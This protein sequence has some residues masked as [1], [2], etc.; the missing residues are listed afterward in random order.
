MKRIVFTL[1]VL[2]AAA[3]AGCNERQWRQADKAVADVNNVAVGARAVLESPAG[4]AIPTPV[5]EIAGVV[6]TTLLGGAA[7]YQ[8]WRKNQMTKTTRAIVRGVEMIDREH[9]VENPNP[10][11]NVKDA[12][13]LCMEAAN[14]KTTGNKIVERLKIS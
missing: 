13:G 3:I 8:T 14:I 5:K 7:A 2:S 10:A 4:A 9:R 1:I 11:R 12:I 6:V